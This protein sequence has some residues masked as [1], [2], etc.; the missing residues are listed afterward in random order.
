MFNEHSDSDDRAP[1][2]RTGPPRQKDKHPYHQ[3]T[4]DR[5][6]NLHRG[7][8]HA[9]SMQIAKTLGFDSRFAKMLESAVQQH[10]KCSGC[11]E[12]KGSVKLPKA[13]PEGHPSAATHF[14][15]RITFDY[16]VKF[17]GWNVLVIEDEFSRYV[18]TVCLRHRDADTT[19]SAYRRLG[20]PTSPT[21]G[22]SD[23]TMMEASSN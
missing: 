3:W 16:I 7:A 18:K 23:M 12:G 15:D 5:L 8:G 4:T 19:L 21:L 13:S 6:W 22:G 20:N 10:G 14:N 1:P 17:G 11:I 2:D 9:S